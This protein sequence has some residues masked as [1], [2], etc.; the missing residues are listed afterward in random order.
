MISLVIPSKTDV[1]GKSKPKD[2]MFKLF[3]V[4]NPNHLQTSVIV[5]S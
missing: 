4:E 1:L 3:Q 5:P 2:D